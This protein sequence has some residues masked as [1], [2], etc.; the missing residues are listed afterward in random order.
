MNAPPIEPLGPLDAAFVQL[1]DGVNHMHIASCCIFAGPP[2]DDADIRA[3]FA[4][5]I[6]HVH[7]YRQKVRTIPGGLGPP[8]WVEDPSFEID[9]HLHR[10]HLRHG[11]RSELEDLMGQ[12]MSVELDRHRPLW[13]AWIVRGLDKGRWALISKVHHAMVDG[14][15]GTDLL[16]TILADLPPV[17]RPRQPALREPTSI[18]LAADAIGRLARQPVELA[19]TCAGAMLHPRAAIRRLPALAS[20]ATSLAS[21]LLPEGR[22]IP[23]DG[24][25]GADRRWATASVSIADIRRIRHLH[26]GT[27]ND[28]VLAAVAGAH[29]TLLDSRGV[30]SS[31]IVVRTLVPVSIRQGLDHRANNQVTALVADL[32]VALDS[33]A[34]RL[35]ALREQMDSLKHTHQTDAATAAVHLAGRAPTMLVEATLRTVTAVL[36]HTPQHGVQT[37]TTNV[38]GPRAP[39]RAL[40]RELLEYLPYVPIYAGMRIGVAALSYVD[41]VAFGV[42]ADAATVPDVRLFAEAIPVEIAEL[43]DLGPPTSATLGAQHHERR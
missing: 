16:G 32:P 40:G 10:L 43:A 1:E 30:D 12:L 20:G 39:L 34:A 28:V 17:D 33:P 4:R 41:R 18:E 15:A 22:R 5:A 6:E 8:V 23:T 3:M 35:A 13:C 25:I 27:M 21:R 36:Q 19:R 9:H 42:T 24:P 7:R 29:R 2:P 14:I 37:V 11:D 26:G 38:P 31:R